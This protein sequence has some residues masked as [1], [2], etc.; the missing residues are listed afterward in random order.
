MKKTKLTRNFTLKIMSVF[1]GFLIWFIVVNVDNPVSSKSITI[2]GE[3]V[4]LQNTAYVDSA[5]MMC[6]QDD[7]P[8]PIRVTITG[9]RRLLSRITQTNIT[10]TADL[11]QAG[12]LD[13]DPVM[14]PITASCPGISPENIKVTPQYLSVRLEEK[15]TQEFLVNVNYG[16]SQPG[17]G[18]EVG[19]QTAS[20]E[21]VKI[22]G[23]KSLV[24]KIDKVNA[25]VDVDGR[26]KDF[27][28]EA[29]LNIIDKNQDS[30][31]GRM[32][33]LTID[34]TKVVVTT[35]FWKIRTG[36]NIGAD[37]VGVP[38]D[39]YQVES[40]TT[41]PDTVSIAGTDE[42]LET[43]KQND[44]TIWIGGADIDITG[45]TTDI[46]KKV[47]LKEQVADF[48]PQ[49]VITRDNVT[50]QIDTVVFFQVMDAKLYTYGVNQPIAAIES[51]SATT[52]RNII[53]EMELDHTLTSRD[54][55]NSKITAILDEATD[56]W[57]IKVNRVEV[58][59]IIPPR[60]IQEAM[61]KQM[62]AE[63]EKRAVIL[64]ADGEKQAAITAAE[65]E[66]EAAILRAD[67]VKQ[68]RI[69]EAEGEAQAI[70]AV[71]KANADAI[72]LLN[73]AMPS[74]KVL[75]IRSLEALAKVANGKATKIIIP[76]ELQ[77][78]GG[79]VPSIKELMT[80]P[81]DAE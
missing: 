20:P 30:L 70:L 36:V 4:E 58:K 34:N 5:N 8:D 17:K 66:K 64:K 27:S 51:L 60:E 13:T 32:A 39:G 68:Q 12:S 79:V 46:E 31:A 81:K 21:K 43:L 54:T 1:I 56:K 52:L 45:E 33:Y 75:A 38:A 80:D 69:L 49:P 15:V 72:R 77:N 35:K 29:E 59:N 65:G 40:V 76:S 48:P 44:N 41:V 71:Q 78:L 37:Y 67:A 55:I 23:P 42:A 19:S 3:N 16:S 61:E 53:G 57:G 18:Y 11:Q 74:D 62:K 9:E 14:V 22:T 63:R 47:S 26:T 6:M 28:E 50:M 73:E 10:L 24:N 7:D 25:T 2:A